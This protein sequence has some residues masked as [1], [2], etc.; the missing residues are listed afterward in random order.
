MPEGYSLKK[1]VLLRIPEQGSVLLLCF[2]PLF[3][4]GLENGQGMPRLSSAFLQSLFSG[5]LQ[6]FPKRHPLDL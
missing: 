3:Q 1:A 4:A 5:R 2:L 6:D